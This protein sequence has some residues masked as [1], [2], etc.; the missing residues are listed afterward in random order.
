MT[1]V[2]GAWPD[3]MLANAYH[4]QSGLLRIYDFLHE[5]SLLVA[6]CFVKE[7]ST[8]SMWTISQIVRVHF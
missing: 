7:V 6:W 5:T 1:W 2:L 4:S 8:E 3:P